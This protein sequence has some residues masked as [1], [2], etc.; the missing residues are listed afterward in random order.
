MKRERPKSVS[1]TKGVG[2]RERTL[3]GSVEGKGREVR[4][5]SAQSW[6]LAGSHRG[7]KNEHTFEL[8]VAMNEADLVHP[9]D[10]SAQLAKHP[11]RESLG[12]ARVPVGDKV[13]QLPA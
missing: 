10:C 1:L 13:E 5:M 6:A 12:D 4:R 8:D 2:R 7:M 11:P 3:A 9:P